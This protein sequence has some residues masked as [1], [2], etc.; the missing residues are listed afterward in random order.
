MHHKSRERGILACELAPVIMVLFFFFVFPMLNLGMLAARYALAM[1]A[2][3]EAAHQAAVAYTFETGTASRPSAIEAAKAA[4]A[5]A[6]AKFTG[7]KVISQDVDIITTDILTQATNRYTDKLTTP[8]NTQQNIYSLE[9]TLV[10]DL[11]PLITFNSP[12]LGAIPGVTA[13]YTVRLFAR[14][15]AENPQGLNQ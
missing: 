1:T 9:T 7:I 4:V 10:C 5:I 13:P 15:Y 2:C 12:F 8:A 14:E 11:E 6:T 3:R